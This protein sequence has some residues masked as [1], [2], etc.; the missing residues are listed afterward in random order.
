MRDESSRARRDTWAARSIQLQQGTHSIGWPA[1]RSG[2]LGISEVGDDSPRPKDVLLL[3]AGAD[4]VDDEREPVAIQLISQETSVVAAVVELPFDD[5]ARTPC[6]A[7]LSPNRA[8]QGMPHKEDALVG[9]AAMVDVG[10][11]RRLA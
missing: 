8:R 4:V 5:V 2:L 3:R 7:V 11:R 6:L 10:V 1:R 9:H